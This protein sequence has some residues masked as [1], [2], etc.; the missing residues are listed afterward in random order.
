[1]QYS[2]GPR[3]LWYYHTVPALGNMGYRFTLVHSKEPECTLLPMSEHLAELKKQHPSNLVISIFHT[4]V[5]MCFMSQQRLISPTHCHRIILCNKALSQPP[6]KWIKGKS[7]KRK[8][9]VTAISTGPNLT[10]QG[11]ELMT[12]HCYINWQNMPQR[13]W[14]FVRGFCTKNIFLSPPTERSIFYK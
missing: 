6:T 3:Y 13:D 2:V 12:V 1:M 14:R 8:V 5:C 10:D 7:P 4:L 11:G 9:A